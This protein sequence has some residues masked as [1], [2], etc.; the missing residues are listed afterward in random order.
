M[1]IA[2]GKS[3][4]QEPLKR[5]CMMLLPIGG[6]ALL[7]GLAFGLSF[8][9]ASSAVATKGED[10]RA[11]AEFSNTEKALTADDCRKYGGRLVTSGE[12]DAVMETGRGDDQLYNVLFFRGSQYVTFKIANTNSISRFFG[13]ETHK[14]GLCQF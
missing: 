10:Y 9:F 12:Y 5:S 14:I 7:F 4:Q 2:V 13:I 1:E 6:I 11:F 8:T 3:H